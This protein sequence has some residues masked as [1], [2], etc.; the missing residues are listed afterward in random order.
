MTSQEIERGNRKILHLT[1]KKKWFDMIASGEKKEEYREIKKYWIERLTWHEYHT[2][3]HLELLHALVNKDALRRDFDA[4][5]FKNGYR[6]DAPT[7]LVEF[8]GIKYAPARPEWIYNDNGSWYFVIQLGEI[9]PPSS[10]FSNG[11]IVN[12][13]EGL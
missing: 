5:E 1:L 9:I 2:Y 12:H 13:A 8:K 6:K 7:L 10:N 3:G 4:V 11:T